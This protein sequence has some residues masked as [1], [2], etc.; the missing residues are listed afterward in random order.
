MGVTAF[1][2]FFFYAKLCESEAKSGNFSGQ[3]HRK[4]RSIKVAKKHRRI[5]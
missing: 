1:F 2:L 4:K 5:K 3:Q